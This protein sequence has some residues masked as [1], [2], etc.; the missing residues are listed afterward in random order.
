MKNR[1][2]L[3]R[4]GWPLLSQASRSV[5]AAVAVAAASSTSNR[6]KSRDVG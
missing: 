2:T 6:D 4:D 1:P 3:L 5:Y